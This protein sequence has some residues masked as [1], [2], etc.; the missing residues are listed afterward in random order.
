MKNILL[1][2]SLCILQSCNLLYY[3]QLDL[4][5][6]YPHRTLRSKLNNNSRNAYSVFIHNDD[7]TDTNNKMMYVAQPKYENKNLTGL[8]TDST[9]FQIHDKYYHVLTKKNEEGYFTTK[10]KKQDRVQSLNQLHI[11]VSDSIYKSLN[12]EVKIKTDQIVGI[13]KIKKIKTGMLW[14][15]IGI[16]LLL[17]TGLAIIGIYTMPVSL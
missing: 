8:L 9:Q 11:W 12:K 6:S 17:I 5:L 3:K 10:I 13:E 4:K 15:Y 7:F 2:L 14:V 16:P 1:L